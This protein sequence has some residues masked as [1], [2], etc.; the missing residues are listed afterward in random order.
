LWALLALAFGGGGCLTGWKLKNMNGIRRP[1]GLDKIYEEFLR[2]LCYS[3]GSIGFAK[4]NI[5][6][7]IGLNARKKSL[8]VNPVSEKKMTCNFRQVFY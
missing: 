7:E 2:N 4:G 6:E 3:I 5:F 1:N 8:S